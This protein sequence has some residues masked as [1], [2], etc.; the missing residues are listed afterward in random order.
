MCLRAPL[1]IVARRWCRSTPVSAMETIMPSLK[2]LRAFRWATNT[3][4][5]LLQLCGQ[6]SVQGSLLTQTGGSDSD[7]TGGAAGWEV[8]ADMIGAAS[9]NMPE[10]GGVNLTPC[11]VCAACHVLLP[12][13]L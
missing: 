8:A 13:F 1:V 3:L 11:S 5:I 4:K 12:L 6:T 10:I 7:F 9:G 2:L